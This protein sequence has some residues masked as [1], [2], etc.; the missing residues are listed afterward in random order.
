MLIVIVISKF[1]ERH[2]KAKRR[3]PAYSRSLRR[4]REVVQRVVQGK[5]KSDFHRVR[6]DRV[7][8]KAGVVSSD[9]GRMDDRLSQGKSFLRD[10]ILILSGMAGGDR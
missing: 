4:I 6:G 9:C 5:L 8:V 7:A 1:L 10:D 3:A 2:S